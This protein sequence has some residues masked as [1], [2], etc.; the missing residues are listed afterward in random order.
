MPYMVQW[1][2]VFYITGSSPKLEEQEIQD[3]PC[4]WNKS[5]GGKQLIICFH[6]DDCKVSHKSPQVL[7]NTNL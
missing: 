4:V 6:V 2:L 5:V 7:N 3:D 1:L